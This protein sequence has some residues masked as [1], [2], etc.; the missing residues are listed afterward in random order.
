MSCVIVGIAIVQVLEARCVV[1][2]APIEKTYTIRSSIPI[3]GLIP[4]VIAERVRVR[5]GEGEVQSMRELLLQTDL[6][7][8]VARSP[9]R[10]LLGHAQIPGD[11][12]RSGRRLC[13][14]LRGEEVDEREL[15]GAAGS[16]GKAGG[17]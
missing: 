17:G 16:I 12:A 5:E 6:Q 10:C 15:G 2:G 3:R 7:R 11:S 4:G 14:V 8:V 1:D 13:R 9:R